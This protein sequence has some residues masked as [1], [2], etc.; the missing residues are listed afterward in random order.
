MKVSRIFVFLLARSTLA[1]EYTEYADDYSPQDNLYHAY[2]RKQQDKVV[3]GGGGMGVAPLALGT[4][5]GY[6][7]GA[8]FHSHRTTSSLKKQYAKE[9]KTL[10]SQYYNDVYKLQDQ[11]AALQLQIE[12]LKKSVKDEKVKVELDALQRDY[13]EFTQPDLDND[14]RISR[15]EFHDYVNNYL[16]NYPGL[17][18]DDYPKFEDFDHDQD[19]FVSFEEYAQQMALQVQ[20][21]ENEESEKISS[22]KTSSQDDF[23]DL[24]RLMG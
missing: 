7:M 18:E 15:A 10:Y 6:F 5:A 13:D 14:D 19:G 21:A 11:N 17:K 3:V 8:T 2:A 16:K 20:K 24:Y 1:Q 22:T 9:Q 4:L 12:G 23:N